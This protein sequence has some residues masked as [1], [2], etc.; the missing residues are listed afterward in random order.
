MK[1]EK[2]PKNEKQE[3]N[4]KTIK[5]VKTD[6]RSY[7]SSLL[8]I[9]LIICSIISWLVWT[10]LVIR[11]Y[12]Q[13]LYI[14]PE[15]IKEKT[16]KTEK[17]TNITSLQSDITKLVKDVS[18]SVVSI[19][20]KKDLTVYRQDPF[21]FLQ[22]PIWT[23]KRKIWWWT[24]FF[25]SKDWKIIT[26][27]HVISDELAEYTVITNDWN[28]FDAKVIAQD[29]VNDLAIL[30]VDISWKV[31]LPLDVISKNDELSIWQFAI[32]IWNT[33]A[34]YQNSVSLGVISWKNR[35][36]WDDTIQLSG[37]IQTDAAI[38]PGNSW[39]PLINLD[40]KVVWIN[41]AIV[42]WA[43]WLGFSI[44]LTQ[45]RISY[46]LRSIEKYW[47]IKKPF[48]WINYI[49]NSTW[50]Q[51]ELWLKFN[52]WAYIPDVKES[53]V[54]WSNAEKAGLQPWD[55]ILEAD[56]EE[57]DLDNTLNSI[58]QTKIPWDT[59]KLKVLKKNKEEKEIELILW[60]N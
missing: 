50:I 5:T 59:I 8:I 39:G 27:K 34:E 10:I 24:W 55:L 43:E 35:T 42:S 1:S 56:W 29:P 48:I 45:N 32:A 14:E 51:K 54:P 37:L 19:I 44:P 9:L 38:N 40:W 26:N 47:S 11:F 2:N 3:K 31:Y 60:E 15:I 52:Y 41:T 20:I 36:I 18:P 4:L 22:T 58:I 16:V 28:E 13:I 6:K 33:L 23:V 7:L 49:I 46:I 30:Q 25:I 21:W 57:I 12:P 53:I 17:I